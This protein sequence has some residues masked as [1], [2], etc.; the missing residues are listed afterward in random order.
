MSPLIEMA[1]RRWVY[2]AGMALAGLVWGI[3]VGC[4]RGGTPRTP[5]GASKVGVDGGRTEADG[6]PSISVDPSDAE[7]R[8]G[9][10]VGAPC[11]HP[12]DC[13][14]GASCI[15]NPQG[16]YTCM[17]HC[18]DRGVGRLCVDGSVCAPVRNSE[19][20]CYT[21]GSTRPG[22]RCR[23][24]LGCQ[25]GTSCVGLVSTDRFFCLEACHRRDGGCP[26]TSYCLPLRRGDGR[27]VC[28]RH[29]GAPCRRSNDCRDDLRCTFEIASALRRQFPRGYCTRSAC[30]S[31][32]DCPGETRCRSLPEAD[33]SICLAPCA[34][35]IDCRLSGTYTCL[36]KEA[37]ADASDAE[38]CHAFR[39]KTSLCVPP[40]LTT[41]R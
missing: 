41:W 31:D 9:R 30:Q 25:S 27:G 33:A 2:L 16:E 1:H 28:R 8:E 29:V 5:D 39:G 15:G 23:S 37:C 34:R 7:E 20:V 6:G 38:R 19:P 40:N 3:G 17:R 12:S 10:E 35:D 22:E 13:M 21:G 18:S 36:D 11:D 24:N 26:E 4:D 14:E 32:R